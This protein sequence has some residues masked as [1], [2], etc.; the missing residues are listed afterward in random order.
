[1]EHYV[2]SRLQGQLEEGSLACS[3]T[4]MELFGHF[5][6]KHTIPMVK[7]ISPD[8]V[9]AENSGKSQSLNWNR[10][11]VKTVKATQKW[12][13]NL[14]VNVTECLSQNPDLSPMQNLYVDFLTVDVNMAWCH[15]A[16]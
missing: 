9:V 14:K 2:P 1:M 13:Q 6:Q 16:K 12:F 7:G 4:K 3:E 15:L 5:A 8:M 11:T 10:K